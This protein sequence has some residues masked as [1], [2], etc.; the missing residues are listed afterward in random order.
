M[1]ATAVQPSS[2]STGSGLIDSVVDWGRETASDLWKSRAF[3]TPHIISN[4]VKHGWQ[5]GIERQKRDMQEAGGAVL[6]TG[7]RTAAIG[8]II[9]TKGAATQHVGLL[10]H[11]IKDKTGIEVMPDL[12][13]NAVDQG[14]KQGV[15]AAATSVVN[16]AD[17]M[18]WRESRAP[19]AAQ[20]RKVGPAP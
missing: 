6:R 1:S 12:V 3:T 16:N 13:L 5:K 7:L 14:S 8:T 17:V 15:R 20:V 11:L 10:S 18:A 9:A 19:K 4:I 2:G